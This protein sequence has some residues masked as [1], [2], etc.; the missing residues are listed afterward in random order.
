MQVHISPP[1]ARMTYS[2]RTISM[3]ESN[4][5]GLHL[6]ADR[7]QNSNVGRSCS[8]SNALAAD[9]DNKHNGMREY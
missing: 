4:E 7:K 1:I 5:L 8:S 3:T 2:G 6:W 9:R